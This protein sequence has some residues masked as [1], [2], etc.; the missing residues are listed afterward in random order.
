M[1]I[2]RITKI[3]FGVLAVVG[4]A[5]GLGIAYRSFPMPPA[6][7]AYFSAAPH[8]TSSVGRAQLVSGNAL[9]VPKDVVQRMLVRTTEVDAVS[10]SDVIELPGTLSLN[11]SRMSH[12]HTRFPGEVVEICPCTKSGEPIEYGDIVREGQLLAVIWSQSLGEKKSELVDALVRLYVE[13]ETLKRLEELLAKGA[14]PERTV[15]ETERTV[16]TYRVAA[17]RAVRTLQSWRVPEQEIE[18]VRAES[19]RLHRT[20]GEAAEEPVRDWA[21]VE[22]RSPRDGV[23]VEKNVALG[24]IASSDLTL[25]VVADLSQLRVMAY[26]Y[27][28]DLPRLDTLPVEHHV[29]K[30]RLRADPKSKPRRGTIDQIG[31]IIDPSQHTAI[32]MGRVENPEGTWRAGQFIMTEIEAPVPANHVR[33]PTTALLDDGR[34]TTV[35]VQPDRL[36]QR[37]VL[38]RV[39]V[40]SRGDRFVLID[41]NLTDEQRRLGYS[42][43]AA[44]EIVVS[45]GAVELAATLKGLVARSRNNH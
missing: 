8:S 14:T 20:K 7:L 3:C 23:V 6:V 1:T 30:V 26:A 4:L 39:A 34:E 41:N 17:G 18:V 22:I 11:P 13:Q 35:L 40:A 24:D 32:V 31:R 38:R 44:G 43:L 45:S 33:V 12:V 10:G 27:E 15:R 16:E 37:F 19:M 42:R 25:F 9:E 29:W 36:V 21:R 28:E 2:G 5:A